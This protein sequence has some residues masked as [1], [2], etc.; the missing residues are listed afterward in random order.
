MIHELKIDFTHFDTWKRGVKRCE[1][2]LNDRDYKAGDTLHLREWGC[3]RG[4][5]GNGLTTEVLGVLTSLQF[6]GIA[7]G[8]VLLYCGEPTYDLP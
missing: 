8:Y 7:P 6:E 3:L 4:Y 1:V 5:T 2:R